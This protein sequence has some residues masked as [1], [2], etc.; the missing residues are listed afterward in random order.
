LY[1]LL[2]ALDM[3]GVDAPLAT[4]AYS[5]VGG[6]LGVVPALIP[7]AALSDGFAP[8]FVLSAKYQDVP[9]ESVTR[10]DAGKALAAGAVA[11]G[12]L[13]GLFYLAFDLVDVV[14][15]VPAVSAGSMIT[16]TVFVVFW[17]VVLPAATVPDGRVGGIKYQFAVTS[18]FYGSSVMILVPSLGA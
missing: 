14:W 15:L 1:H 10:L 4:L 8:P 17:R 13:F 7:M 9:L 18:F 6:L 16:S 12:T 11:A 2:Y 3:L 5:I